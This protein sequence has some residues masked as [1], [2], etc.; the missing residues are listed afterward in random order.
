MSQTDRNGNAT[1]P[2][3]PPTILGWSWRGAWITGTVDYVINNL[4]SYGGST[5]VCLVNN[6]A[7]ASFATDLAAGLWA[8]FAQQ[9]ASGL[10]PANNLSDVIDAGVSLSNL[11]GVN[12]SSLAN[13]TYTAYTTG[14]TSSAYTVTASPA[15]TTYTNV[16]LALTLNA[17][18]TGSP[19]MNWNALG[20]KNW[21][22]YDASGN[23]QFVTSAQA[24]INQVTDNWYDGT[25]VI[26]LNPLT[27]AVRTDVPVRQCVVYGP[28]TATGIADLIPQSQ[29]GT[30]A[31]TGCTLKGSTSAFMAT[32]GNGF[33]TDGSQR[34]LN[35]VRSTDLTVA[36]LTVS[37]TN[38][39][40]YDTVADTAGF[41]IVA[42]A[43]QYGGT[44]PITNNQYT[45]DYLNHIMYLGNGATA[46][47]SNRIIVA[48]VDCGAANI[49]AI[50][51]RAY[52]GQYDSG[53]T[54][55]LIAATA[56]YTKNHN[57]GTQE[58]TIT[59]TIQCTTAEQG[60]SIG[61]M[62][63]NPQT[64]ATNI[65]YNPSILKLKNTVINR[66]GSNSG[67]LVA[68]ASTGGFCTLTAADWKYKITAK[69][70]L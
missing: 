40:W 68:N 47:Q 28:V 36:G 7:G 10:L 64:S 6:I 11:Q 59:E 63:D 26:L 4:V 35:K 58:V 65:P 31:A 66:R 9:G 18:P 39:I 49:S 52:A 42:D 61:D 22:Y 43:F 69:R 3:V 46:V 14:G 55:T 12:K 54:A 44:I 16:R 30:S 67:Y 60:Y 1:T 50:R 29:I 41:V 51:V 8:L 56:A 57:M 24:L 2:P 25:D 33:N 70:N 53:Y 45:Y 37:Q 23:K 17:T 48:E 13:Q 20:A 34:N 62:L 19:T 5:Y 21:K 32:V 15:L 38:Y 27:P